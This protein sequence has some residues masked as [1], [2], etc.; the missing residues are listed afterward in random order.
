MKD[1][2][3]I[4]FQVFYFVLIGA[5]GCFTPYI[6]VYLEQSIGLTGSEIG[7]ITAISLIM[8]VC[9]IPVW[10]IVGDKTRKYN[11][12]LMISIAASIVSLYF[13]SKQTVYIGCVIFALILEVSRL[14]TMPM[15]DTISMNYTAQNGGNYGSIRGMG[16][17][18]Y[19]LGS[20]AVGFLAD[21]FGLDGPLFTSYIVLLGIGLL[22]CF[23]FP[24]SSAEEE[25]KKPQKGNFK[26]LL[27]NKNFIFMLVLIMLTQI[28]I[29]S[30]GTYAGNHLIVTL[31]GNNSLISWLTLV[32]VLP[33]FLFL[34][35]ASQ[36]IRK[37]GYKKF[38]L[39]ATIPMAIR[40]FTYAFVP[41]ANIFVVVSIVHCLGVACST[42]A[43]L[44]Y[45]Q[46]SVNPAVFGTAIT[47]LNAAMNIGKAIFGYV[48][49]YIYQYYGSYNI[50]LISGIIVVI[51]VVMVL[52]TKRFDE[53]DLKLKEKAQ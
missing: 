39:L 4:K 53:A 48:F 23:T 19:M 44:A 17:L 3:I 9:V 50:F 30:S 40:L 26:E 45:I 31:N 6:N 35:V 15:A 41:N 8:G 11:L 46:D 49:G 28:V 36:V 18:G 27:T 34:M 20:M 12:L 47:L 10:G 24:K 43:S 7:L 2:N 1:K 37:L 32:Q 21:M 29:D 22:I 16:S 25:K 13:Y 33:E 51:G 5:V 14:G 52:T 38:F 42:V